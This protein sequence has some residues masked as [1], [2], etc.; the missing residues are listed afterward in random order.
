MPPGVGV[1]GIWNFDVE[2]GCEAKAPCGQPIHAIP[3]DLHRTARVK[4]GAD[5]LFCQPII[6]AT[7]DAP[8][9]SLIKRGARRP[10]I[11]RQ[12]RANRPRHVPSRFLA[13]AQRATGKRTKA[14][15]VSRRQ[16]G[17]HRNGVE[18]RREFV[19]INALHQQSRAVRLPHAQQQPSAFSDPVRAVDVAR[20]VG[21][22]KQRAPQQ[23]GSPARRDR[24]ARFLHQCREKLAG[25]P[26]KGIRRQT[27]PFG[28][29]R[30]DTIQRPLRSRRQVIFL[31]LRRQFFLGQL[32]N[33]LIRDS[34]VRRRS[35]TAG[36][37]RLDHRHRGRW[38]SRTRRLRRGCWRR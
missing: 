28:R 31:L 4:A 38:G 3:F 16:I 1:E 33:C 22:R 5:D 30:P 12:R 10:L 11:T 25:L 29:Q 27:K 14:S 36:R 19:G 21:C 24:R 35:V 9:L 18:A 13:V 20:R 32:V 15:R 8:A 37:Q 17:L 23:D 26:A 6:D 2:R 34:V 7:H